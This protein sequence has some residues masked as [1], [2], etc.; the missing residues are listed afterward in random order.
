VDFLPSLVA[1]IQSRAMW[2][3]KSLASLDSSAFIYGYEFE[4]LLAIFYALALSELP[5]RMAYF[6][7]V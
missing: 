2:I 1:P 5:R 3:E 7:S 4:R 6:P